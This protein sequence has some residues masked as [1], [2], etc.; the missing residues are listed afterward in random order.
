MCGGKNGMLGARSV[1]WD[2]R[3]VKERGKGGGEKGAR[4]KGGEEM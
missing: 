2:R 3:C 4:G 1:G